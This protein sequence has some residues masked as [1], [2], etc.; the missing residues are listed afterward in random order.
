MR[1]GVLAKFKR[2]Y[3]NK[4]MTESLG[5]KREIKTIFSGLLLNWLLMG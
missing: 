4:P 1:N 2:Q 5:P 3:N